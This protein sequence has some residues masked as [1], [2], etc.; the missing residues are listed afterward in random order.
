ME[1]RHVGI[2]DLS[3]F[4][5]APK[6]DLATLLEHRSKEAP[7]LERRLRRAVESTGQQS[8]RYPDL[9]EDNVTLSAQASH[10]LFNRNGRADPQ[11]LRYLAV[12]TE[13]S[14]DHSKPVSAYVE[15]ALQHAGVP[16]PEHISTFQVQHACA[17]GTISMLSVGALLQLSR[18]DDESGL[19]ICSDI[20][21]YEAPST[22]EITQG[23]GAVALL[24][25]QDPKLLRLDLGTQGYA[26]RDVDDFFRPLGSVTAKVKGG[27]SVQCYN[28]AFEAAF[29]DHC[30][31]R[32][33]EPADVLRN[34]DMFVVHVPFYKM[35]ITAMHRLIS[36]H[37][38]MAGADID[39]F[40]EQRGFFESIEP[41]RHVGNIYSGSAYMALAFLLDERYRTLG[42]DL[43]GKNVLIASYGSG[44]TMTVVSGT[45]APGAPEVISSWNLEE[46]WSAE[47]RELADYESWLERPLDRERYQAA[48]DEQRVPHGRY[49]LASI[50]E[51]GYREYGFK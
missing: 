28:E 46:T 38:E 40:L 8:I 50:R 2:S 1:T 51:D 41:T 33:E 39:E 37:T 43:V 11:R 7:K 48:F 32:G 22:A 34:T 19:V 3:L 42:D 4:V 12:G 25:E 23:A 26:S 9:W 36:H 29:E 14:V 45:V 31:R 30:A 24:I 27:Y 5:P 10:R 44:N 21:R 18:R 6:M 13:T 15:G 47:D 20:A 49:Y 17:G 35:G 16:I